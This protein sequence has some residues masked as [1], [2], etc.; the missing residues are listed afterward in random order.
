M[1]P[2]PAQARGRLIGYGLAQDFGPGL[3]T[4]YTTGRVHD[5]YVEPDTRLGGTG[6]T[7]MDFIFDWSRTRPQPMILD[8]QASPSAIGFYEALGFTADRVGDFPVYPGFTLDHRAGHG[9]R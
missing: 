6:R 5:L 4:T 1:V 8:W 7:L 9:V 2:S 3:R